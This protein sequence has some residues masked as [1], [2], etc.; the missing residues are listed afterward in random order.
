MCICNI[1]CIFTMYKTKHIKRVRTKN[2]YI[3]LLSIQECVHRGSS[4]KK[5]EVT[6][7]INFTGEKNKLRFYTLNYEHIRI[8]RFVFRSWIFFSKSVDKFRI[9]RFIWKTIFRSLFLVKKKVT[10]E[11][12][13]V[14]DRYHEMCSGSFPSLDHDHNASKMRTNPP[15]HAAIY[16]FRQRRNTYSEETYNTN[17]FKFFL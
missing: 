9:T 15:R 5:Y 14:I 3:R 2:T 7:Y 6:F 4:I 16:T 13:C 8:T 12:K 17:L 11:I 10:F 1:I